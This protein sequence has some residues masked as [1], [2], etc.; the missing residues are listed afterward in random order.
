[1]CISFRVYRSGEEVRHGRDHHAGAHRRGHPDRDAGDGQSPKAETDPDTKDEDG[2]D[3]DTT[4]KKDGDAGDQDGTDGND[5][6][7][8]DTG[9]T[10][11]TD[12]TS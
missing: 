2:T 4:D 12:S 7:G 8:T 3:G 10:D 5:A 9:D 6:D 11:G 1:M